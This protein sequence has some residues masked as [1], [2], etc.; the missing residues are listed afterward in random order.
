MAR[1]DKEPTS[2]KAKYRR[3]R[4]DLRAEL[5][6]AQRRIAAL[7]LSRGP[8][9]RHPPVTTTLAI[10]LW[11]QAY[12]RNGDRKLPR[13]VV[14]AIRTHMNNHTLEGWVKAETLAGYTGLSI[15]AVRQQI[16]DNVEAGWLEIVQ[17]GNSSGL[18]NTYRLKCPKGGAEFTLR[19][20]PQCRRG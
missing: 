18:A 3:E 6:E 2:G 14:N 13:T 8:P 16:A 11:D 10:I 15:R 19:G 20:E 9:R 5:A 7:M 17:S 12:N 4:N 1:R